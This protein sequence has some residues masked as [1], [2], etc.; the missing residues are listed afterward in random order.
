MLTNETSLF[1]SAQLPNPNP[2]P[3]PNPWPSPLALQP[4][5]VL[6]RLD[7]DDSSVGDSV[8]GLFLCTLGFLIL[9]FFVL[10]RSKVTYVPLTNVD[11]K[12]AKTAK[13]AKAA[14]AAADSDPPPVPENLA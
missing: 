5:Q 8:F 3:N 14:A 9:A 12:A 7:F 6:E 4:A 2:N 10:L 13:A 1:L 11:N